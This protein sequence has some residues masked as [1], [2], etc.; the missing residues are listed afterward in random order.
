[1]RATLLTAAFSTAVGLMAA[2]NPAAAQTCKIIKDST[3]TAFNQAS[4]RPTGDARYTSV[5]AR[6]RAGADKEALG[7]LGQMAQEVGRTDDTV[8]EYVIS[9]AAGQTPEQLLAVVGAN[10][11]VESVTPNYILLPA[12]TP[13]DP[14]YA[15]QWH[16]R[17]RGTG[18]G[19]SKAGIGLPKAWDA[20]VGANTVV[21]AVIDTGILP[22]EADMAGANL[23]PGADLVADPSNANDGNGRD[24]D[25]KDPGDA[26]NSWHG[27]HVAGTIGA[28]ATNNN[29]G[30]ASIAWNVRV[31]PVRVLGFWGGTYQ[32]V[33]DGILWAVGVPVAGVR[34][35]TTPAKILNLSLGGGAACS[36]PVKDAI[37]AA[38]QAGAV[39]VVAAGNSSRDVSL[40]TPANCPGAFAVSAVDA[41]AAPAF[42]SNFGAGVSLAAPGGD[43]QVDTDGDGNPD[44]VLSAVK[45]GFAY[46]MGTSMAAPHVAGTAALI[47]SKT[48]GL[49]RVQVQ[50]KLTD[51]AHAINC[52]KK[53]GAGLLD[54]AEALK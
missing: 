8:S 37:N 25:P 43:A 38:V 46:Y 5:I 54:A 24:M 39:V 6:L 18:G 29:K 7:P 34:N 26:F 2:A 50:K 27:T 42:Y 10:S 48:P 3:V 14:C 23:V 22:N 35:N 33:A 17:E 1:M 13:N 40:D 49:T 47:W 9:L 15:R 19:K 21:V 11:D 20:T 16:Y 31:Q 44:G 12:K 52:P 36:S 30:A 53:C 32:D 4:T 41:Q 28:L 51:T 45:G